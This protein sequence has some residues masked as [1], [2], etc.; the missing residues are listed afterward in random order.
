MTDKQSY[1]NAP[2]CDATDD[3]ANQIVKLASRLKYQIMEHNLYVHTNQITESMP[4]LRFELT[5]GDI[6]QAAACVIAAR[7]G[8]DLI[9]EWLATDGP[10]SVAYD[11]S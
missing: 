1:P 10:K 11:D 6:L 7:S 3:Y 9:P 5:D 2:H 8:S 4:T